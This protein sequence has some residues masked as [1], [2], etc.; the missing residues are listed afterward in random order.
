MSFTLTVQQRLLRCR[1]GRCLAWWTTKHPMCCGCTQ[2]SEA[3]PCPP[4]EDP[5]ESCHGID[6]QRVA[7]PEG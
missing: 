4:T 7:E 3:C 5:A 1:C 6:F 2:S